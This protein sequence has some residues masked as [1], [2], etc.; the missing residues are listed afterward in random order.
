[1]SK[2]DAA[3]RDRVRRVAVARSA[4]ISESL[5]SLACAEHRALPPPDLVARLDSETDTISKAIVEATEGR[6]PAEEAIGFVVYA[7][8]IYAMPPKAKV[9]DE[10]IVTMARVLAEV[11]RCVP[12]R[13]QQMG[14]FPVSSEFP[15]TVEDAVAEG[16]RRFGRY[17]AWVSEALS[18]RSGPYAV[19][20]GQ[21]FAFVPPGHI[22]GALHQA[23]ELLRRRGLRFQ[24]WQDVASEIASRRPIAAVRVSNDQGI[25]DLDSRAIRDAL[26]VKSAKA[27]P[28]MGDDDTQVLDRSAIDPGAAT[29][30]AD[31][32][33]KLMSV[34]DA[35]DRY[36]VEH[37]DATNDENASVLGVTE[38]AVRKGWKRIEK[39][40]REFG[41]KEPRRSAKD[42]GTKRPP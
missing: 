40:A 35:R 12:C 38:G 5:I 26:T 7:L 27:L 10:L 25:L 23:G 19:V 11:A 13:F 15:A 28:S 6:I 32:L 34:L 39:K 9:V 21:V 2:K 4:E 24:D 3:L 20:F 29:D 30:F 22:R 33:A 31:L 17:L 16:Q 18:E 37:L 36:L 14:I 8:S 1:M 42:R 41:I